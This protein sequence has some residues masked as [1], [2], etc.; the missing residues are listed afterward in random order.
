MEVGQDMT[1]QEFKDKLKAIGVDEV[2]VSG[3][4]EHYYRQI[5]KRPDFTF[6]HLFKIAVET[7]HEFKNPKDYIIL[8]GDV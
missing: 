5:K 7:H 2:I 8:G 1:E 6:D 4:I 3:L